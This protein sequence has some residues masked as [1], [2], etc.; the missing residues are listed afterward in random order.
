MKRPR[1]DSN[2]GRPAKKAAP[3]EVGLIS[4][5]ALK[6]IQSRQK[7]YNQAIVRQ[8]ETKYFDTALNFTVG[9]NADWT[10]TEVT[11]SSYIQSDGTTVGAYTDCALIPS[12]VGA[13]YGQVTGSKYY[14]KQLRCRGR[15]V[16]GAAAD[17]ADAVAAAHVRMVL[18]HDTQPNGAQAQGEDVFNDMGSAGHCVFSFLAMGSGS[19]GRFRILADEIVTLEPAIAQ[20]DGAS[21]ASV[22]L[23]S[24]VFSF[25]YRP[26]KP[27]QIHLKANSS[28]P[29]VASLSDANIFLL[30]KGTATVPTITMEGT[31]RC[32]YCE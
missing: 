13:G 32:Y 1:D 25:F 12:A 31:S 18:V 17:Q 10:A 26:K 19:G 4:M 11:C 28:T 15:I 7:A 30:A 20:T 27:I 24:K 14:L 16:P 21:T 29:T 23:E 6:A 8:P 3:S 22:R 2:G 9:Q 5:G